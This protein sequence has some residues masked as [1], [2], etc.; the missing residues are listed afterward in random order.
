MNLWSAI[1]GMIEVSEIF[2]IGIVFL[3]PLIALVDIL[4]ARLARYDKFIWIITVISLPLL[5]A[6]LYLLTEKERY[7]SK[8]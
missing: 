6:I 1:Y 7:L 8:T 5:G 2:L 3:I 4:R